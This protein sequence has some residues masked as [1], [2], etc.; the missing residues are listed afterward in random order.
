MLALAL[1]LQ[2]TSSR[3]L[4]DVLVQANIFVLAIRPQD[5]FKTSY[6]NV[7]KTS[8]RRLQDVL[9]TPSRCLQ[10]VFKTSWKTF[11]TSSRHLQD[12]FKTY[13][14]V[15]PFLLTRLWEAFNTFLRRSFPKTITYRGICP[16]NTTSDKFMVR[17]Q[18]LQRDKNFPSF[19]F[20]I[21]Y[22]FSG[23]I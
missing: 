1:R 5:F 3:R 4:E 7:F 13:H 11:K 12:I 10:N 17:V 18:N 20:S 14:Q 16:G 19:S 2:K 6:I 9:K 8:S 22:T 23:C 21:Y 15:K